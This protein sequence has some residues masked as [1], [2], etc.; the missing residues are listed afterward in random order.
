[1]PGAAG[2]ALAWDTSPHPCSST[3]PSCP[4]H[5]DRPRLR[6]LRLERATDGEQLLLDPAIV[7]GILPNGLTYYIR[8]K[9]EPRD[10][11][12]LRPAVDAGS[13]LEDEDQ[14]GLAH[15]VEHM[16]LNGTENYSSNEIV[17]FLEGLGMQFDPDINA[18]T[19]FD[20]TVY[21]LT[22]PTDDA[23]DR[24][25]RPGTRRHH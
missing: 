24:G 11:A 7:T 9:E 4:N 13:I 5:S 18:Y 8:E 25:D 3:C 16:A 20:E 6:G 19:S 12:L 21:Q 1:M 15:F 10:R 2:L 22:V 23:V 17:A 14:L